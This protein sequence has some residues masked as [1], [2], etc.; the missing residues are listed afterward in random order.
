MLNPDGSFVVHAGKKSIVLN[1]Y[2]KKLIAI[3]AT[4]EVMILLRTAEPRLNY[5][6]GSDQSQLDLHFFTS[7]ASTNHIRWSLQ[8]LLFLPSDDRLG[9]LRASCNNFD[10]ISVSL[11]TNR[12]GRKKEKEKRGRSCMRCGRSFGWRRRRHHCRLCRRYI[13][14]SCSGH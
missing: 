3:S 12:K 7:S 2:I 1:I 6:R 4:G 11:S 9:T 10:V 8:D 13:C 14:A 5:L